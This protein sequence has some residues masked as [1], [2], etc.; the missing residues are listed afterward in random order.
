MLT[1]IQIRV[2]W[3][4]DFG[5]KWLLLGG[6]KSARRLHL[7]NPDSH[8]W[9]Y[10]SRWHLSPASAS[11]RVAF[12]AFSAVRTVQVVKS[13]NQ[14]G[15]GAEKVWNCLALVGKRMKLALV[16]LRSR[17]VSSKPG[18]MLLCS[19]LDV[20]SGKNKSHPFS[21]ESVICDISV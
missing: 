2:Q 20:N 8:W 17:S 6:G 18:R 10:Y 7:S 15:A 21:K 14:S 19:M 3:R 1:K 11:F 16:V 12:S 5:D 4:E 13:A 9:H